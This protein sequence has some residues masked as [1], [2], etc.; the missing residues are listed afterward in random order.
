MN[1]PQHVSAASGRNE[2]KSRSTDYSLIWKG[3][4]ARARRSLERVFNGGEYG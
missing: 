1:S 3:I 2:E 4:E